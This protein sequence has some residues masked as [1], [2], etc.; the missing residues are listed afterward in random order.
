MQEDVWLSVF[1]DY[2][3][4]CMENFKDSTVKLVELMRSA[5]CKA[6]KISIYSAGISSR[7]IC[8]WLINEENITQYH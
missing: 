2:M 6:I 3:I 8:K 7:E 4:L 5:V 1:V